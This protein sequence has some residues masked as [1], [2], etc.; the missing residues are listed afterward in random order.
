MIGLVIRRRLAMRRCFRF[1]TTAGLGLVL[2]AAQTSGAAE[3]PRLAGTWKLNRD[4]SENVEEK[5][6]YAA[7]SEYMQGRPGIGAETILPWGRKFSEGKRV[8]LREALLEAV[9]I[10]ETVEIEQTPTEIKTI[11]GDAGVRIFRFAR[12]SSGTS[13]LSEE[14]VTRHAEWRDNR[15]LLASEGDK[16]KSHEALALD[17]DGRQ[18]TYGLKIEMDLLKHPIELGLVYDR[19]P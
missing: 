13:M 2:A 1:L 12:K 11:H 19:E 16:T 5:I 10:L 3:P 8:L 18:L 17:A 6:K 7:G 4:L 9:Q 15:L 14:T